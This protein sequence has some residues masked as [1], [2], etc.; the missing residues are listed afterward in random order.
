[1]KIVS[2]A[3]TRW[4]GDTP[5]PVILT[6]ASDL[7]DFGF[8]QRGGIQ[9]MLTFVARTLTER[10]TGMQVVEHEGYHCHCIVQA[11]GLGIIATCD[12]EYPSRVAFQMCKN[13]LGEFTETIK[14]WRAEATDNAISFPSLQTTLTKYQKPTEVDKILRI[15]TELEETKEVLHQT[16]DAVLERGTKLEDLVAKSDDLSSQSKMFY[17]QAKKTNSCC[18]IS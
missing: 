5:K 8:F 18:T 4:N 2:I 12:K 14:G 13:L 16:I 6:S 15:T 7:S 3:I 9:E 17:K 1:M 10:T 11:D